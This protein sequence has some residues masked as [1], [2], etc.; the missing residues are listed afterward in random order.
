MALILD[1]LSTDRDPCAWYFVNYA[2]DT[3]LGVFVA[4]LFLLLLHRIAI[5]FDLEYIKDMGEYGKPPRSM[6]APQAPFATDEGSSF[7]AGHGSHPPC[8][9]PPRHRSYR[10]A[11]GWPRSYRGSSSSS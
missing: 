4:W 11:Y 6:Y 9:P 8:P 3:F 10:P 7:W 5:R 2:I 1:H